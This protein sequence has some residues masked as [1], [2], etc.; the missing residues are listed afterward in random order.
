MYSVANNGFS[1]VGLPHSAIRGSMDICSYPRLFAAYHG[2]LRLATPR[3]PPMDPYSLDHIIVPEF[4]PTAKPL[5]VLFHKTPSVFPPLA[6]T[7]TGLLLI[8][9]P[10]VL[11]NIITRGYASAK[12]PHALK[13]M[14]QNRVELLT[15][16]LSEKCSNRLSYWP[17]KKE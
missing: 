15:P 3:H 14:G 7:Q 1:P 16:S 9:L 17:K 10:F 12:P 11:S 13:R 5:G 4:S 8:V 2:L 6:K